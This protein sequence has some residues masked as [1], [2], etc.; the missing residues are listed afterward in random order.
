MDAAVELLLEEGLA[1]ITN[2]SVAAR[3]GVAHG[4]VRH[5]F[6][7]LDALIRAAVRKAAA[8]SI[9][10]TTLEPESGDLHDFAGGLA[11]NVRSEGAQHRMMYE[12]AAEGLR[13]PELRQELQAVYRDYLAATERAMVGFGAGPKADVLARVV[14][15]ALDGL[16][17]QELVLGGTPIEEEL[18]CLRELIARALDSG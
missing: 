10:T 17:L 14:F 16:V 3:A 15:A 5:H 1:G 11:D 9:T 7:T 4:L 8:T 2:R 13:D 18:A 6:R 12:V